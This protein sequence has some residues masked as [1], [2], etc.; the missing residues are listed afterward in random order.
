MHV[1]CRLSLETA[2]RYLCRTEWWKEKRLLTIAIVKTLKIELDP[3]A[4]CSQAGRNH[5]SAH[6]FCKFKKNDV[7]TQDFDTRQIWNHHH[8]NRIRR[9]LCLS[10]ASLE[11]LTRSFFVVNSLRCHHRADG[12]RFHASSR[13]CRRSKKWCY[14]CLTRQCS[15][16]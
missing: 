8:N 7:D 2:R 12:S 16:I 5:S 1:F 10:V 3:R 11:R 14:F 9:Y 4:V 6:R 13:W 15:L